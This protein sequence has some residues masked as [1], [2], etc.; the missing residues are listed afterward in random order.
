MRTNIKVITLCGTKKNTQCPTLNISKSDVRIKDDFGGEV[1]LT[2]EQ[3]KQLL[4]VGKKI[5]KS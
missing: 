4:K 5:S 1:S 2:S 3:F